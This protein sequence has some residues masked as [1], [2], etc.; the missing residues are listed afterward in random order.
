MRFYNRNMVI[1]MRSKL[2]KKYREE[3]VADMQSSID[4]LKSHIEENQPDEVKL[5]NAQEVREGLLKEEEAA[6]KTREA[7][8][9][10]E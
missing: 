4:E 9:L 6:R 8:S 5:S 2:T 3:Q 10:R 7:A 1:L